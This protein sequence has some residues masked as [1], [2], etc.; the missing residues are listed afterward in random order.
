GGRRLSP[1]APEESLL[2]RKGT[3]RLPHGGGLRLAPNSVEYETILAWIRAGT[4]MVGGETHG[5]M[6]GIAVEPANV[7]LDEPGPQQLRV[8]ARF[9]D[10][11]TRDVTRLAS[12]RVNDDSAASIDPEGR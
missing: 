8:V 4:P 7:R 9:A 5:K 3:G 12:F 10:G 2:L 1:M 6:T 11:H